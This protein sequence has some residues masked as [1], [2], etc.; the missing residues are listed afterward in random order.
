MLSY[1]KAQ[2]SPTRP[3]K[4]FEQWVVNNFG[5]RLFEIFFKTYTEKVWGMPCSEISADWAAQRIKGLNLFQAIVSSLG[6]GGG[7]DGGVIK[8]LIGSF[9][10][11]RLGPGQMWERARDRIVQMGGI[12]RMGTTITSLSW[13]DETAKWVAILTDSEGHETKVTADHLVSTAAINELVR[14]LGA[15]DEPAVASAAANLR[16]RDFITVALIARG[17]ERFDDNWIYIHDPAVKVGRIQNFKSWSPALVPDPTTACYGLEYF[18]FA[19][20]GLWTSSDDALVALAKQEMS[21]LGLVRAEDVIDGT[22]IRQP[23]AYPVYDD[24]Y[25]F[26]VDTIREGLEQRF[27][28]LHLAGRNGMHKYNNQDHA[29]MTGLLTARNIMAGA[30]RFD[31]WGVNEDAEYHEG[32]ETARSEQIAERLVPRR[33]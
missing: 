1:A 13:H 33:A 2:M 31:V 29:M 10:Y 4:T 3:A 5:R 24:F 12:V 22:V 27:K 23:K 17:Q 20:D 30:E 7:K 15:D 18:C 32:G 11:P 8:T 19:G 6:L 14:M 9:R 21:K 28:N 16:Y 26:N 25:R